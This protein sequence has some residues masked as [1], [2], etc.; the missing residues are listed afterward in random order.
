VRCLQVIIDPALVK[1]DIASIVGV[2]VNVGRRLDEKSTNMV[3]A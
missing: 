1:V 3:A 2:G